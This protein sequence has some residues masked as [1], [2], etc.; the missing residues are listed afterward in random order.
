MNFNDFKQLV[1]RIAPTVAAALGGPLAGVATSALS[2]ILLGTPNADIVSISDTM[3][4][5]TLK[6]DQIMRIKELENEYKKH[7][8][9]M[10]FQYADLEFKTDKMYLEDMQ[11]A[12]T[13]QILTQDF[14]PQIILCCAFL[15][16]LFQFYI[17]IYAELP[18]DEFTRALIVRGFGTVDGILIMCVSYFVGS[19]RGSKN[20]GDAVRRIAENVTAK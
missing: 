10:G 3:T 16:Y 4:S 17:F 6:P 8:A 14:M 11:N 9:E 13:R 12:R 7:E 2:Q 1:R 15:F 18:N 19:S 20:S 5:G